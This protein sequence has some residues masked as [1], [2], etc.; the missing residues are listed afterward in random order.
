M[1][2]ISD[3]IYTPTHIAQDIIDFFQPTGRILEP[4][5]G[6]GSF[7]NLLPKDT[8]WCEIDDNVDFFQFNE[9]VDWIVTNP[10]YSIFDKWLTHSLA[11]ADNIIFLIPLPKL[12]ASMGKMKEVY[13]YGGI[14]HQRYYGSGR[15]IGFPFG[16]PVVAFYLKRDYKSNISVTF[17]D[18]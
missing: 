13:Q 3:K 8:L 9:K 7:Y 15:S 16:F 4:C 6:T 1:S 12:M 14:V 10:P 2:N 17:Y 11:L 18:N 5:R